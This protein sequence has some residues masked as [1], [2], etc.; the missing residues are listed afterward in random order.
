[1][2]SKD[3]GNTINVDSFSKNEASPLPES[4]PSLEQLD[5]SLWLDKDQAAEFTMRNKETISK[6]V[7]KKSLEKNN[8][9]VKYIKGK[10]GE[11]VRILKSS[12]EEYLNSI[13]DKPSQRLASDE[14]GTIPKESLVQDW[15]KSSTKGSKD[16]STSLD[17]ITTKYVEQLETQVEWLKKQIEEMTTQRGRDQ[18]LMLNIQTE[19]KTLALKVEE[20]EEKKEVK[21][22]KNTKKRGIFGI[23]GI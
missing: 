11:E 4:K 16:H 17:P 8:I 20:T 6:W 9:K 14:A 15:D 19:N 2:S 22:E 1:M 21:E 13:G 3:H 12:L 23:F 5:T 7:R 18:V 10:T